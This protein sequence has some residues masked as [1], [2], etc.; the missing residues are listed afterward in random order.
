MGSSWSLSNG[1]L[2]RVPVKNDRKLVLVAPGHFPYGSIK[3]FQSKS[4]EIGMGNSWSLP[5]RNWYGWVALGPFP[6]GI[7]EDFQS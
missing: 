6:N 7:I 4:Q 5:K 2:S 1:N 3:D